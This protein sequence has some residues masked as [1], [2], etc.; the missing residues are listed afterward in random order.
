MQNDYTEAMIDLGYEDLQFEDLS[1]GARTDV[2]NRHNQLTSQREVHDF[3]SRAEH[4]P[5]TAY[6]SSDG[7]RITTWMGDTLATVTSTGKPYR[8][9]F[10]NLST[11][12]RAKGIDGRM[13]FGRH[14]GPG[15]YLRLRPAKDTK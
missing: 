8:S 12:F 2:I 3:K 4:T 9:N 6:L 14:N 11:P 7:A 5:Y 10:G 1:S 13:Y 15:M